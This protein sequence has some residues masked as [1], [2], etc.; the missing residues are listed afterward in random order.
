MILPEDSTQIQLFVQLP[1]WPLKRVI[2]VVIISAI[3]IVSLFSV[4]LV[5]GNSSIVGLGGPK[6]I[7]KEQ[8]GLVAS[9]P[10]NGFE[11]QQQLQ[12]N[13]SYWQYGGTV[14]SN[15]SYKFFEAA[16]QLSIGVSAQGNGGW[17]G[18][19][20][21]TPPTNA[22]LVHAVLS[23]SNS[24][25]ATGYYDTG[26]YMS[27]SNQILNY[28]ACLAVTTPT[29]VIWGV[30]HAQSSNGE[31]PVITPLWVDGNQNQPLTG[32]CAISTNG[33]NSLSAYLNHALVYQSSDLS[34]GMPGPYSFYV[35]EET[36]VASSTVYA[37]YQDFYVTMGSTV[38]VTGLPSNAQSLDIVGTSGKVYAS[39]PVIGSTAVVNVGNYTY[40]FEA[41]VDAYSSSTG[42]SN[43]TLVAASS[44]PESVYGGDIYAFGGRPSTTVSLSVQ[45]EDLSGHDLTGLAVVLT[46]NH[47]NLGNEYFPYQFTLSN[48]QTYTVTAYDYGSYTFD[49]WSDGSTSRL[50]TFSLSKNTALTAYY[51]NINAAPPAGKSLVSVT[52]VDSTGNPLAGMTAT[53]WLNGVNVGLTYT[54]SSFEV[55]SGSIYYVAASS[56]G[57]YTFSHWSNGYAGS[58]YPIALSGGTYSLEAVYTANS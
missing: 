29:G 27:A 30:V 31:N 16:N 36:S 43:S 46:Q 44:G 53:I 33:L 6:I 50:L 15:G 49:H 5:T 18:Y 39:A 25:N 11:T 24:T 40:P 54:P 7:S 35:E 17:S 48:S 2:V 8:S 37:N 52:A 23:V 58:F 45:A 56:F 21:V 22:S 12:S 10:L 42:R 38:T 51:R 57:S 19:Y 1:V 20:A 47:Q 28:V 32:D 41:Y 55:K 3:L 4:I 26:L 14:N 34:L 13:N 9:D